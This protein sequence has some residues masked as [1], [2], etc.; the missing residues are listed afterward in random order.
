M[1]LS[2]RLQASRQEASARGQGGEAHG[3]RWLMV[4]QTGRSVAAVVDGG[5]APSGCCRVPG[6][7]RSRD[8]WAW[9]VESAGI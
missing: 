7:S 3:C 4:K 9:V 1:N 8:D 2:G 5:G 6:K